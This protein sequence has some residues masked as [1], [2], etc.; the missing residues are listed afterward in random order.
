MDQNVI[1]II[2]DFDKTLIDGYMQKPIF[3]AYH[4]DE[5]AFWQ[6]VNSLPMEYRKQGI[7]VNRDTIY[8]NHFIT[9]VQQGIFPGLNNA[10]LREF[11]SRLNFYPGVPEIFREL[12]EAVSKNEKYKPFNIA[13]EHYI[14]STGLAEVI[15]GSIVNDYVRGIWGCE[16]IEKPIKSAL[17]I[18]KYE[19]DAEPCESVISQIAYAIDNTS[20]T[21]AIFEINKGSNLFEEIDVNSRIAPENRRVPFENMIYIADGP[22]DV[23]AFSVIKS[24]GGKTF[25]VYPKGDQEAFKQVNQLIADGRIDMLGEADYSK[26]TTTYL[27]LKNQV[28]CIAD[29][30]YEKKREQI[31]K[32]ASKAPRHL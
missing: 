22:S 7:R 30:I 32:S 3:E 11:G 25:A 10:R 31:S 15:R 2:W 13:V 28:L 19:K 8:L 24:N 14:V 21:R 6:E 18:R 16:F 20:K 12:E 23:P 26:D 17:E 9:C 5:N 4:V 27:W 29:R 1:A